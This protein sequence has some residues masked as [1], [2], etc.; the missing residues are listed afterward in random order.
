MEAE[1]IQ[2]A[3]VE[4]STFFLSSCLSGWVSLI[5]ICSS[6]L[7]AASGFEG[8]TFPFCRVWDLSPGGIPE[9]SVFY[10]WVASSPHCVKSCALGPVASFLCC[11]RVLFALQ[12]CPWLST[13][14]PVPR[15]GRASA[16]HCA[17]GVLSP[18][19]VGEGLRERVGWVQTRC[20][21]LLN[22][23]IGPAG[24]QV[25]VRFKSLTG[26]SFFSSVVSSQ[27]G[28]SVSGV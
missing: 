20:L 25:A 5:C 28:S 17:G 10:S 9:V 22:G 26:F 23:Q 2:S 24:P 14:C 1:V 21:R 3:A 4:D 19:A 12:P 11:G 16:G 15:W 8:E 18:A 6:G 7:V 27:K 13:L